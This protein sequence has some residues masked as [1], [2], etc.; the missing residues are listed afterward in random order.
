M[1]GYDSF[2]HLVSKPARYISIE[3][4]S[5]VKDKDTLHTSIL[6]C[7]PEVYEIGMAHQGMKILY[8]LLNT[9]DGISCERCFAPWF[10]MEEQLR[11]HKQELLS[12]ESQ[13]PLKEFDFV[14]FS[15]QSELTFTNIINILDISNI[16]IFSKDR[17]END[18]IVLAGGPVTSNPEP[19]ADFIDAFLIGDGE[20]ALI[21]LADYNRRA[22][23]KGLSRERRLIGIA[24][25]EGFYVPKFYQEQFSE[26]DNK[27]IGTVAISDEV[28]KRVTRRFIEE[29]KIENYT[30]TP[31]IPQIA[32]IQDR[33]VVE[34]VRGCTQGCRFCQAGY[35][36]RPIRELSIADITELT[37]DGLDATGYSEVGLVS[38]STADYSDVTKMVKDVSKLTTPKQVAISLPSLRADRMSV[39][40]ADSVKQIKQTGFTFAPEAG[41][42]R[43]RRVINKNITNEE[44]LASS[45]MVF[46]R[47]WNTIKLYFMVGLPTETYE[48]LDE[49]VQLIKD[50]E[51]IAKRSGG[52]RKI[53]VSFGPFIPKSHTPFQWD[54]YVGVEEIQKRIFYL[55]DR[56]SS[57]IVRF[58]WADPEIAHFEA[59]VSKGGRNIAQGLYNAFKKGLRFEGWSEHFHYDKMMEAFIE[60]DIDIIKGIE[61]RALDDALPWDHIDSLIKKKFLTFERKK[62]FRDNH[63]TTTDCR[64]GDCHYCGIPTPKDDIKL[65]AEKPNEEE[66]K[67]RQLEAELEKPISYQDDYSRLNSYRYRLSYTKKGQARFLS[68]SDV[69][70]LFQMAIKACNFPLLY[71]K[72]FNRKAVMQFGPV[73]PLGIESK[74]EI[75]DL[76]LVEEKKDTYIETLNH[77][78]PAGVRISS[79][80]FADDGSNSLTSLFPY[81]LY[82]FSDKN[83]SEKVQLGLKNLDESESYLV[84]HRKKQIDLKKAICS[85]KKSGNRF[86]LCVSIGAQDGQNANPI[87]VMEKL[88][89]ISLEELPLIEMMKESP[90]REAIY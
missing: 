40:L 76:W 81:A 77:Y 58:K 80:E 30:K 29:L 60:A 56:V 69:I 11:K 4:N 19:C 88:F 45:E 51:M 26:D 54:K 52:K 20:E 38:L 5:I 22:K 3:K 36:Y 72:G 37:K 12:L 34:V 83:L 61:E 39:Q 41:S 43:L 16:P 44:L 53:N 79:F 17:G 33:H 8:H 74:F 55:K 7:F 66:L 62:A 18:P 87:M 27:Y 14:G 89:N 65:K 57:R 6:L 67:K 73:L 63:V 42:K 90:L 50:I 68:H 23:E 86:N 78:L 9:T 59:I 75:M 31:L 82:S 10:D 1:S 28:P 49:T 48:D 25:I 71:T 21:E 13:T 64:F 85:I 46:A 24:N 35:I 2:L 70:R 47:G 15:L 84:D 32:T